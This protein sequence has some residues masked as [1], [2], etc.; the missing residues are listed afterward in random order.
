MPPEYLDTNIILR[1]ITQD[2]PDHAERARAYLLLVEA[3]QVRAITREAVIVEAVQVL[4]SKRLYARPR[5][6]IR[7]ALGAIVRM[8]GLELPNKEIYLRAL[9]LYA[10]T[11]LDFV[12]ALNV[13]HMGHERVATIVSFDRGYDRVPGITRREP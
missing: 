2:H 12:D 13:A 5:A 9:E 4:E 10:E 1:H 7:D 3:G 8:A 11:S 6:S